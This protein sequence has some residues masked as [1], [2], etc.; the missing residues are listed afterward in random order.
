MNINRSPRRYARAF[1]GVKRTADRYVRTMLH[2]VS[3]ALALALGSFVVVEA[4]ACDPVK[5]PADMPG[6][7]GC[8]R[9]D[10]RNSG[11][12][13]MSVAQNTVLKN[14]G[15][16]GAIEENEQGGLSWVYVRSSGSVFGE[17]ETAEM[18]IFNGEGLLVGT[19]TEVRKHLGKG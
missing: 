13:T 2:R 9:R 7:P 11:P 1:R 15:H 3:L 17:S 10:P 19:K 12:S 4:T 5:M 16:P 8:G 18:F 14:N 6:P